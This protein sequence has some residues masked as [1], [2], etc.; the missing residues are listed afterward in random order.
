M[1]NVIDM[2]AHKYLKEESGM[3]MLIW[4]QQEGCEGWV[5]IVG[6][7]DLD[8]NALVMMD[9]I[10][11]GEIGMKAVAR[12]TPDMEISDFYETL[13]GLACETGENGF[14]KINRESAEATIRH[15]IDMRENPIHLEDFHPQV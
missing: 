3:V 13:S 1:S 9:G 2:Q 4:Q 10:P 5:R 6:T 12:M 14:F 7:K 15:L 11:S 8:F